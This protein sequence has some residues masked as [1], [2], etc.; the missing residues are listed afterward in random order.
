MSD[1]DPD[2]EKI[3]QSIQADERY[4]RNL[5]WGRPRRGHPEGTV[6]G[7]IRE[8]ERNLD[9]LRSRISE[10]DYGKLQLLIHTHDTFK[11]DA[12][13]GVPIGDPRSHA[14]LGRKFLS[15]FCNDPDL[16]AMVQYHDEP[17]ALWKQFESRAQCDPN[18]FEKLLAAIADWELFLTFLIIDGC[19]EGKSREPLIWFFRQIAGRVDSRVTADWLLQFQC[20]IP[21]Q[22]AGKESQK[23]EESEKRRSQRSRRSQKTRSERRGPFTALDREAYRPGVDAGSGDGLTHDD[24]PVYGLF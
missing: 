23:S 14:S 13:Q 24:K 8:L 20:R 22:F 4:Q 12:T 15:E 1:P 3:L 18:R 17:Y 16:L 5:D 11:A 10:L 7:H 2:Y 21:L 9:S 6:R 19:T